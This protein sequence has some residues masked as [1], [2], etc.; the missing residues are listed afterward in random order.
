MLEAI[1]PNVRYDQG[2]LI[3]NQKLP[4]YSFC[5][6]D[7]EAHWSEQMTGFISEASQDHFIDR[8]NR[9]V[10]LEAIRSRM[11]REGASYA[12]IGCSSGYMIQEV[13]AAFPRAHLFGSDYF[14]NGLLQCHQALPDVPL[15]QM[16]ITRCPWPDRL[17][18]AITCLNVLEHLVDDRTAL[19]EMHRL[20]K[21]DGILALTVPMAPHLYDMTDEI[22]YHVR[23]YK[24]GDLKEK[25]LQAGF[26]LDR[27]NYFGVLIYPAFYVQKKANQL[28]YGKL[29][30]DQKMEK[31][32]AQAKG[33]GRMRW[34]EKL[35]ELELGMGKHF[36][37]PFG[38]RA[39]AIARK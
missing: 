32:R 25:I 36:N 35:C 33:T 23:R 11:S 5:K 18:D 3:D 4:Y 38:I 13:A 19:K 12:D 16:D 39:Y 37:F 1:I 30:F 31:A 22:H 24:L 17:L 7:G 26:Q 10:A 6:P 28:L 21:D 15:F 20:L 8:Y 2:F 14:A 27:I 29:P 34:M 9:H